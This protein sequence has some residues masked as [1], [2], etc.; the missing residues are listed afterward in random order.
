MTLSFSRLDN[1]I[2][3]KSEIPIPFPSSNS[4]A[5][6]YETQTWK[7]RG[8]LRRRCKNLFALAVLISSLSGRRHGGIS[9][10]ERKEGKKINKRKGK[11]RG[12]A[13]ENVDE[14]ARKRKREGGNEGDEVGENPASI[15]TRLKIELLTSDLP[16][17]M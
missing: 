7:V 5:F 13:G 11:K 9:A 17:G 14:E 6:D 15:K 12:C 4:A 10:D 16:P 2:S 8:E 1:K 3:I